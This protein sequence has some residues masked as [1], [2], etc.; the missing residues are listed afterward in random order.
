MKLGR[1][2]LIGLLLVLALTTGLAVAGHYRAKLAVAAYR[3]ELAA[4]GEK[5]TVIELMPSLPPAE[6]NSAVNYSLTIG[7][8]NA[9]R[10]RA[11]M[12]WM[13]NLPPG[14]ALLA[15][16]ED[17]LP[18]EDSSNIWPD[19]EHQFA[20]S[21]AELAA[22]REAL[23]KPV[24][25][26]PTDYTYASRSK[27]PEQ[28]LNHCASNL[29]MAAL[30][31]LRDRQPSDAWEDLRALVAFAGAYRGEPLTLSQWTRATVVN[32]GI[33]TTWEMLQYGGWTEEQLAQL[34]AAW[35]SVNPF[36]SLEPALAMTRARDPELFG[37]IRTSY[38]NFVNVSGASSGVV[39]QSAMTD[40]ADVVISPKAALQSS[41]NH[42]PRFWL[43]SEWWSYGEEHERLE[44][45]QAAVE[46]AR[47]LSSGRPYA[48]VA[49]QLQEAF[50][51][52]ARRGPKESH[53]ILQDRPQYDGTLDGLIA[54][55]A[56]VEAARRLAVAALAI[57]R[58]R[59]ARSRLPERLA[60]LTPA[61]LHSPPLDP[62]NGQPTRYQPRADGTFLLYSVGENGR[63]DG[64]DPAIPPNTPNDWLKSN[65]IV[66][67]SPANAE[68]VRAYKAD[69]L[70]IARWK[71]FRVKNRWFD[72]PTNAIPPELFR[73]LAEDTN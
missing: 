7:P 57:E 43:W 59:L 41:M 19:V 3:R 15:W 50:A 8:L 14:R 25:L 51:A 53:T 1:R 62:M 2:I 55:M 71:R 68:E 44:R 54:R 26:F 46:A 63:D 33:I 65:D 47:R 58:F 37:S 40:L 61:F 4:Q 48:I 69:T 5:V 28:S 36:D 22:A 60:E 16:R 70:V 52:A 10:I 23:R 73:A 64:G 42:W 27:V 13:K 20:A 35:E 56:D 11:P 6:S 39:P 31:A 30:L 21:G 17:P 12:S 49:N 72:V 38:T 67:P 9:I 18:A 29:R 34:Q 32:Y 24:M 66:W 45:E